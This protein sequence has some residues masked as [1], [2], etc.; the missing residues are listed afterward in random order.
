MHY[1]LYCILIKKLLL[2]E[3]MY[4][5]RPLLKAQLCLHSK[6]G[7]K[8]IQDVNQVRQQ[9][10][11]KKIQQH[12]VMFIHIDEKCI[13]SLMYFPDLLLLYLHR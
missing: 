6:S 5:C 10:T 9:Q 7:E 8:K 2:V 12:V 1:V 4:A 11:E 3:L 13:E